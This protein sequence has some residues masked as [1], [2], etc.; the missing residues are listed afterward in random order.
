MDDVFVERLIT[1]KSGAKEI[2]MKA[3]IVIGVI[4]VFFLSFRYLRLLAPIVIVLGLWGAWT[5]WTR[6]NIEYEYS[7]SNG[8]LS[9]SAIYGQQK[10]KDLMEIPLREKLEILAPVN[11]DFRD[12]L[13]RN[14]AKTHDFASSPNANNRYFMI[15]SGEQGLEKIF[16]EPDE[17]MLKAIRR[18]VPSKVKGVIL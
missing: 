10:R 17:K 13:Q 5:F 9:V 1:R 16:F 12:E 2:A 8:E 18:V 15:V 7:L 3:L 6:L 11:N 14:V 4:L